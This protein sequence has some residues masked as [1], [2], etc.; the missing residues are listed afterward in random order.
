MMYFTMTSK[1]LRLRCPKANV[2]SSS[3]HVGYVVALRVGLETSYLG[4]S[5]EF[6]YL[7][8]LKVDVCQQESTQP[9][10]YGTL[11]PL[12]AEPSLEASMFACMMVPAS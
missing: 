2:I 12:C 3:H 1:V 9:L 7:G 8:A 10:I 6:G 5:V 11:L 4:T